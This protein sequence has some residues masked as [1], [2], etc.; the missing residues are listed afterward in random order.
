GQAH[1]VVQHRAPVVRPDRVQQRVGGF[2]VPGGG[3]VGVHDPAGDTAEVRPARIAGELQVAEAVVGEPGLV[4]LDTGRGAERVGVGG[5]GVAIGR[6]V[7]H[8]VGG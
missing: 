4:D 2:D 6:R 7:E 1:R 3:D 8:S 5:R